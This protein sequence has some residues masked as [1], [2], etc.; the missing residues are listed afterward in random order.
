MTNQP[1]RKYE[2]G[3]AI[4]ASMIVNGVRR[5][6]VGK[7]TAAVNFFD[8]SDGKTQWRYQI[9]DDIPFELVPEDTILMVDGKLVE[10]E[11]EDI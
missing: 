4:D 7:I 5:M 6:R 9:D 11:V 10:E 8:E 1:E 2:N 3:Q